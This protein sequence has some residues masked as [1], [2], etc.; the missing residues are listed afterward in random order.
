[1]IETKRLIIR[2][3]IENDWADLFEYLSLKQIYTYEPGKPITID[4]SKQ[5]AKDR[6]KGDDFYAVVLKENMK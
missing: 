6:S 3:F 2:S 1:M 4:E 5:I